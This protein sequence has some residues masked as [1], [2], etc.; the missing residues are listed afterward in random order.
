MDSFFLVLVIAFIAFLGRR[1]M[2]RLERR[3]AELRQKLDA[4][5]AEMQALKAEAQAAVSGDALAP[6]GLKAEAV[7]SLEA[8]ENQLERAERPEA[9]LPKETL[10]DLAVEPVP[11]KVPARLTEPGA[12]EGAIGAMPQDEHA[13]QPALS[14]A[15]PELTPEPILEPTPAAPGPPEIRAVKARTLEEK[16]GAHWT[17]WIGG[18]ALALGAV[19]TVRYSIERGFFGPGMRVALGALLAVALVAGGEFLRRRD[20]AG[21]DVPRGDLPEG[22]LREGDLSGAGP[23]AASSPFAA[24][25][26]P[27]V[28]TA[29]GTVAAF[30]T[31]Y[32]AHAVYG[33]MGPAAAFLALGCVGLAT[34]AAA[35]L[36]GPALAGLGLVGA[37]ATPLLVVSQA[38]SPWPVIAYDL[39]IV[40]SAYWLARLKRWLWLALAA[41]VGAALWALPFIGAM[42]GSPGN[43]QLHASLVHIALQAALAA[44]ALAIDAHRGRPDRHA[45][46]DPVAHAV[47]GGFALL[48]VLA[49][50]VGSPAHFGPGWI[51]GALTV[52][53]ILAATGVSTA[54]ACGLAAMGSLVALSALCLW[55][56]RLG[57]AGAELLRSPAMPMPLDALIHGLPPA[58]PLGFSA[59]AILVGL[60]IALAAG[61]RLLRGEE[62]ALPVAGIHAGTASLTPLSF[63]AIAYLRFAGHQASPALALAA[64]LVGFG[65]ALATYVFLKAFRARQGSALKL[66]LGAMSSSAIAALSLALVFGLDGGM[67]TVGLALA[68]LGTALVATHL[69]LA[70]LRW[71]VAALGILVAARMAY[72]PRIVGSELSKTPIFNW[73]LFGYGVPAACFAMAGRVLRRARDDVPVH[74]ADALAVLFS[75]LLFFF[76]IRHAMN[77]GD[78]FARGSGLVEQG[79]LAV[80]SLGFSLALTRLDGARR[81]IVFRCASIAA[82]ALGIAIAAIGLLLRH[83][84]FLHARPLEGGPILNA[85]LLGYLIPALMAFILAISARRLRPLWFW[86]GAA[87]LGLVLGFAFLMLEVRVLFHGQVV[88]FWLGAGIA[89]LGIDTAICL[90]GAL[91]FASPARGE[92]APWLER[93][94]VGLAVLAALIFV[95]GLAIY[96]NPLLGEAKVAG[97]SI[98]NTLLPGYA[99]PCLMSAVLARRVRAAGWPRY[100]SLASI[101]AILALFAY[102]SLE[103]RRVFQGDEMDLL[104]GFTQGEL[105]AYSA[106]WLALGILL[107]AY[108]LWRGSREARLASACFIVATVLKVFLLDLAGLEGMLRALSFI[109]LG[110]VLIGI[111]LVYQKFVFAKKDQVNASP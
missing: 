7:A 102:A 22:D 65:F 27:G 68:A 67:L 23:S 69:D 3:F 50:A 49:L 63:L 85:L 25:Y 17:V 91:L 60:V 73:L 72:E 2:K 84:P 44:Y 56:N 29:S 78:P 64:C 80:T 55:P 20:V 36:H 21:K 58:E 15:T 75:A 16:L 9:S 19:L 5:L 97:G 40:A 108:G 110:A 57:D 30:A 61:W 6:A 96:A 87:A 34:M 79:L 35:A 32:S 71:C 62:L 76:E 93:I 4:A 74:V 92:L 111:G 88:I 70:A 104:N 107:L 42:Q 51:A 37:L 99:L 48:A 86:G 100:A 66:G 8:S 59:F 82:G 81:N 13:A 24:P 77:G 41:A 106:A 90:A 14:A 1:R 54:S 12:A 109:G 39:V 43:E 26:I 94:S 105:Y 38:P 89:E 33:F 28:L 31:I 103:V 52:T 10:R 11:E 53:A 46:V 18:V 101:G 95:A 45:Y 47:L 83:N 98:V